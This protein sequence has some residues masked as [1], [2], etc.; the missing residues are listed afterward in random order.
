MV[1][2]KLKCFSKIDF[3]EENILRIDIRFDLGY[4]FSVSQCVLSYINFTPTAG[5]FRGLAVIFC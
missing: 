1:L 5:Y 3:R 2:K 4:N